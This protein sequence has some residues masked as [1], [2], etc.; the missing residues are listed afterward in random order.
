MHQNLLIITFF[1]NILTILST[2]TLIIIYLKQKENVT[3]AFRLLI[4][5][6]SVDFLFGLTW[7]TLLIANFIDKD[8]YLNDI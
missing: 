6:F 3:F 8:L 7:F 2:G 4:T 5:L 1:C